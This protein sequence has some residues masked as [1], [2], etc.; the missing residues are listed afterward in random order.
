MNRTLKRILIWSK[1]F[2]IYSVC[3]SGCVVMVVRRLTGL[4]RGTSERGGCICSGS[5][6]ARHRQLVILPTRP[7]ETEPQGPGLIFLHH[8]SILINVTDHTLGERVGYGCE[9]TGQSVCW[10]TRV[11][12]RTAHSCWV[13][14]VLYHS[15]G[16][17]QTSDISF[18]VRNEFP[19]YLDGDL[20]DEVVF[21]RVALFLCAVLF[22]MLMK[23]EI[24][25]KLQL[26][27]LRFI[28]FKSRS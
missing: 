21:V 22:W 18:P 24:E 23:L 13:I 6:S 28:F 7:L 8:I 16:C 14:C 9:P 15:D 4:A 10:H 20:V 5:A 19:S 1:W 25:L 2:V 12:N 26:T 3:T 27:F 11:K 17:E